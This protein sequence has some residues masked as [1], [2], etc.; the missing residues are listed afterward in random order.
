VEKVADKYKILLKR[1]RTRENGP[2]V[3]SM[4]RLGLNYKR[5]FGVSLI[6][7]KAF[8]QEY[9]GEQDL[10]LYLWQKDFRE[11]KILSLMITDAT[12]LNKGQ[13]NEYISGID[14]IELAEQAAMHLFSKLPQG[15]DYALLWC[16][17]KN[18]YTRV[19]ALLLLS[20]I[21]L[22]DKTVPEEKLTAF[23]EL[24]PEISKDN[25][26]HI[27]KALSRALLQIGRID[28]YKDKVIQFIAETKNYNKETA[29]WLNEEVVYF[30]EN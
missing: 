6:D 9:A 21:V 5:S 7:L 1:F 3:D 27:K 15:L 14:N 22:I 26:F 28:K 12:K 10:A 30:L 17:S 29:S 20:R 25:N 8:A 11:T 4:K 24:F 23:F 19:T 18:L 13:I 16:K 2:V